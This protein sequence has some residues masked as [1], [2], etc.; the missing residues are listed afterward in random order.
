MTLG[1]FHICQS[2]RCSLLVAVVTAASTVESAHLHHHPLHVPPD[3]A[4]FPTSESLAVPDTKQLDSYLPA[5]NTL[6]PRSPSATDRTLPHAMSMTFS[7]S[8]DVA[9]LFTWWHPRSLS[10]YLLSLGIIFCLCLLNEWLISKANIYTIK[11][12]LEASEREP[13]IQTQQAPQNLSRWDSAGRTAAVLA[14]H[15]AST[16]LGL[17][18]MLLAMS[19]NAGVFCAVVVGVAVGK[20]TCARRGRLRAL[21]T[22]AQVDQG[23]CHV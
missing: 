5:M 16:A 20:V 12:H 23:P 19:F 17:L 7:Q 9:L 4:K 14:M 10:E 21:S 15:A 22:M 18:V 6:T 11:T 3:S 13:F 1:L 2:R 8:T